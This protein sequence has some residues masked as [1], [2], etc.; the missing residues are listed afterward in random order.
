M[1][2][3]SKTGTT[4]RKLRFILA[5]LVNTA[6]NFAV[7]NLAFYGLRQNKLTSV[8]LATV[9]A[10]SVSFLINRTFVF[11]DKGNPGRKLVRF[12]VISMAGVF[13]VQNGVYALALLLISGHEAP[14][15]S[16]AH[17]ITGRGFSAD[18]IDIN[19]SNALASLAVMLWNYNGYRLFVFN[20]AGKKDVVEAA[21][22]EPA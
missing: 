13:M 6:V 21:V 20:G 9:C 8:A 22:E 3:Y 12:V 15:I 14:V 1:K 18:F 2:R 16:A 7:L 10:I 5:G 11:V 17:S 19:C 4:G